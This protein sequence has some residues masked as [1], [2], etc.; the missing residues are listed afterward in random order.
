MDTDLDWQTF[1]QETLNKEYD[2]SSTVPSL[3]PYFERYAAESA[4]VR[5]ALEHR[6]NLAYGDGE[7]ERLDLFPAAKAGAPVLVF[8]HGGYWRRMSK[9]EFS[10]VAEPFVRAGAVVAVPSYSLAPSA[11]L[12]EIVREA[13]MVLRW[14]FDNV[15]EAN[16][17]PQRIVVCGH[18]AG[19]QLAGMLAGTDWSEAGYPSA[20]LAGVCGLSGLY[21]LEPVR[22]T[23][24]NEWLHLDPDSA[25]RNSPILRLPKVALPLV[26]AVGENETCEF[27]RQS[28][29][30]AMA[31]RETH[32]LAECLVLPGLN[33][34]EAI[35][36]VLREGSSLTE[37]ILKLLFPIT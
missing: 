6:A 19:A 17:D 34:Y 29:D 25:R 11:S 20:P 32:A 4:R 27:Q 35:L 1:D 18:S 2:A 36:D 10:F 30:Y 12:D 23:H 13:R 3:E 7:R 28:R 24:I 8:F 21:D 9:D 31:W 37:A 26:A 5:A 16:G 14:L 33:H 15:R 22:R